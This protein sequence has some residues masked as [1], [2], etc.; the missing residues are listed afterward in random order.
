MRECK[1]TES[2]RRKSIYLAVF[3]FVLSAVYLVISLDIGFYFY[4]PLFIEI[5]RIFLLV[6]VIGYLLLLSTIMI[7]NKG[8]IKRIVIFVVAI[9]FCA[10]FSILS[11]DFPE[12]IVASSDLGNR[13]YYITFEE[14]LKEPRTTLRIYRCHTNQIRCDRIYKTMW[15]DWIPDIEMI[16]DKKS[17]EMH[18]LLER[19]LFFADGESLR[20]IV[21]HEEVGNYYYYISVYPYNWFSKD[22]HTYRLHKCPVTF[23]ACDQLPFQYTDM[24]TGFD[25]VFDENA[26]ELKVYKSSYQAEDTLVYT[27]GA[28]AKCY[29]DECSIPEE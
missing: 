2:I 20:E 25:I 14:Y 29:V 17:N 18:V 1:V 22:E 8:E 7:S 26:D 27:F 9:P 15:V 28:E 23:I 13:R 10:L 12:K 11:L 5:K 24:A 6:L 19:T 16:A 21:E 3:L 4:I